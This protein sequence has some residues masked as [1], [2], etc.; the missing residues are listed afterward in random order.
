MTAVQ[1]QV[2]ELLAYWQALV[3]CALPLGPYCEPEALT[4]G[5][6]SACQQALASAQ[7]P[8]PPMDPVSAGAA[9]SSLLA[10]GVHGAAAVLPVAT[11]AAASDAGHRAG[12]QLQ[13]FVHSLQVC[14][15]G[16]SACRH[17]S[18]V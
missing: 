15:P 18:K 11:Q 8:A 1:C 16:H 17:L 9:V 5:A 6:A 2:E 14:Y 3:P 13:L 12:L 10:L 4:A 7:Q